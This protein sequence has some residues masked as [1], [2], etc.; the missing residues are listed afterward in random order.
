MMPRTKFDG[1]TSAT[2]SNK[3]TAFK[4]KKVVAALD[5]ADQEV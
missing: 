2:K 3:G 4:M 5:D 1:P